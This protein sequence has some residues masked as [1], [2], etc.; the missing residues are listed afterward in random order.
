MTDREF[1]IVGMI[2]KTLTLVGG[3]LCMLLIALE[4]TN[5]LPCP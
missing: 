4:W 5:N 2:I 3:I 1:Y